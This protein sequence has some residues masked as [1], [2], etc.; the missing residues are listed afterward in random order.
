M[1][2]VCAKCNSESDDIA[3][4]CQSC[5]N[6][7]TMPLSENDLPEVEEP[8]KDHEV[9][10]IKPLNKTFILTSVVIAL[11]V[12]VSISVYFYLESSKEALYLNKMASF[13][14]SLVNTE[15]GLKKALKEKKL[16]ETFIKKQRDELISI[17]TQFNDLQ[18][19][20][21]YNEQNN[22]FGQIISNEISILEKLDLLNS[23]YSS[24]ESKPLLEDVK[25]N[26]DDDKKILENF[27]IPKLN[28]KDTL[29]IS[30]YPLLVIYLNKKEKAKKEEEKAQE[31]NKR[32]EELNKKQE[33][34][35]KEKINS[36]FS[37]FEN[38][39]N[40][41]E[42]AR[43]DLG[44]IL[45]KIRKGGFT[46]QDFY[47]AV[48]DARESR[49]NLRNEV[50]SLSYINKETEKLKK[51]LSNILTN[52]IDYCEVKRSG[53]KLEQDTGF[54][55]EQVSSK[56]SEADR[57]DLEIKQDYSKFSSDYEKAKKDLFTTDKTE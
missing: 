53:I 6:K 41:Y 23:N 38:I 9:N 19:P 13:S 45:D 50:A 47:R 33:E 28:I 12:T 55:S 1:S 4:F 56:Y 26:Y 7:L 29:N 16:D 42:L 32:K 20:N 40:K 54:I 24:E 35:N 2:K 8:I 10:K 44:N 39:L 21:K 5:G 49:V 57:I 30:N 46:F 52:S 36:F 51:E 27:N 48:E 11:F 25:K 14:D 18:V 22:K 37:T 43:T 17:K 34:E 31:E 15:E 3:S